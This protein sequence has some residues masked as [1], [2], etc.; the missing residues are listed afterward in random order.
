MSHTAPGRATQHHSAIVAGCD[1]TEASRPALAALCTTTCCQ[2]WQ[3][4]WGGSCAC[5]KLA[6]LRQLQTE[7][8]CRNASRHRACPYVWRYSSSVRLCVCVLQLYTSGDMIILQW[9]APSHQAVHQLLATLDST[10][11]RSAQHDTVS[12]REK[13]EA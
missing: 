3:S 4:P 10:F 2:R 13:P 12:T 5:T 6:A 1:K 11:C 8:C 7:C 9:S